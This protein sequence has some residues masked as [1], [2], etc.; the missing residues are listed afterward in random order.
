[1]TMPF[2]VAKFVP[3]DNRYAVSSDGSVFSKAWHKGHADSWRQLKP[4]KAGSYR[5]Y[6]YVGIAKKRRIGVH[7]LVAAMFIGPCPPGQ[8]VRHLNGDSSNNHVG[9]LA[10]GT[11]KTN[12]EDAI[13]HGRTGK[14]IKNARAILS[15]EDVLLIRQQHKSGKTQT[16]IAREAGISIEC[17]SQVVRRTRWGWLD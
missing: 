9:N 4:A 14:G 16:E 17:V 8:E 11:R 5:Q 2:V 3:W 15:E 6:M 7:Q 12:M 1:M 10:Y 13:R